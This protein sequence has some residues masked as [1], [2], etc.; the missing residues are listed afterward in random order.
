MFV[1]INP[2]GDPWPTQYMSWVGHGWSHCYTID[3]VAKRSI[4]GTVMQIE[5]ALTNDRLPVLKLYWKFCT[6]TIHNFAVI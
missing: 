1:R 3:V 5:K 4:K 6:R 2:A